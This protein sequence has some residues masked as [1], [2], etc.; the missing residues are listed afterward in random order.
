MIR[1]AIAGFGIST[2]IVIIT[3]IGQIVSVPI[4]L[5][6]WGSEVYGEWV[7]LTSLTSVFVLFG[8]GVQTYVGNL[9]IECYVNHQIEKGNRILSSA[10][11][12]Y[13][14]LSG[15]VLIGTILIATQSNFIEELNIENL[16]EVNA[17]IIV[18]LEGSLIAYSIFGGL[19]FTPLRASQQLPRQLAYALV[20]RVIFLSIPMIVAL[21]G[22]LPVISSILMISLIAV[23]AVIEIRDIVRRI[24]FKISFRLGTW[25]D[26]FNLVPSSLMFL[27]ISSVSLIM[28][29]GV[30]LILASAAGSQAVTLY[31]TTITLTNLVRIIVN[32][33]LNVLW[34]EIT[35]IKADNTGA[36]GQWYLFT[37]KAL[38]AIGSILAMGITFFGITVLHLWT[39]GEVHGDGFLNTILAVYLAIQIFALIA[40]TF[41]LATNHPNQ[42]LRVEVIST[43][44]TAVFGLLLTP[45]YSVQGLAIAFV[46]GQIV[47]SVL[48]LSCVGGW[49]HLR[50]SV[51]LN[52]VVVRGLPTHIILLVGCSIGA[53][54]HE[55]VMVGVSIYLIILCI[56]MTL[57]W[58]VWLTPIEREMIKHLALSRIFRLR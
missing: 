14:L 49:V 52:A 12:L 58:N 3:F 51:V 7:T 19:L 33:G 11:R 22:G 27:G 28:T 46:L 15:L 45:L 5:A 35:A 13:L 8:L 44:I 18:L 39:G 4:L 6:N 36:L 9:L 23:L 26:S 34:P 21:L 38:G 57:T 17:R 31:F 2:A 48:M 41:G 30:N 25:K 16:S 55:S 53:F 47:N 32:Q 24:P 42:I 54:L 10:L 29:S 1:R 40:R 56:Y 20:E 50:R 37:S 43:A